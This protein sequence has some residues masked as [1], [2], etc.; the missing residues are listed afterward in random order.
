MILVR[1]LDNQEIE[2]RVERGYIVVLGYIQPPEITK[3]M[4]AKIKRK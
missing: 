3:E 4:R 2:H 1:E